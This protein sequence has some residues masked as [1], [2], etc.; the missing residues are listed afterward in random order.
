MILLVEDKFKQVHVLLDE[1]ISWT[2]AQNLIDGTAY[3][4][5]AQKLIH[6]ALEDARFVDDFKP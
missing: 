5:S 1:L 4:M 2:I 6:F 3:L